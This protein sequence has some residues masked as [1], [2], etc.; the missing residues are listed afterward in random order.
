MTPEQIAADVERG[1]FLKEEIARLSEELKAIEK[2]LELAGLDG[3]QVP[4]EDGE[5]EGK[6][7]IARS[8][9]LRV[10]IR[11]ESDQLITTVRPDSDLHRK[12]QHIL[13]DKFKDFFKDTRIFERVKKDDAQKFRI[14][15]RNQLPPDT[16]AALISA[17]VARDK[18][19]IPKSKTVIAWSE[20]KPI[21]SP[22]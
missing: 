19:G 5:R 12:L 10:P 2:R 3:E 4:L 7:Y 20:A 22:A 13:G 11:F 16:Y 17:C 9:K 18:A 1:K 15:A 6:Q 14:H 8:S 21:V